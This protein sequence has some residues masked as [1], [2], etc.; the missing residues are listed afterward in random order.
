M[1]RTTKQLIAIAAV[2]STA[3]CS[4]LFNTSETSL[5]VSPAFQTIPMGFSANSNSFDVTGDAGLPFI[6][7]SMVEVG[8]HG[9]NSGPGS[10]GKDRDHHDG[11]GR[12][13]IR[14]LLM[15]GGIGPDF[16][17]S[18]AFGKGIGR[19][20]FGVFFLPETCTFS[21]AT[22]RVT[23][24]P[25]E[26]HGLTVN[27]SAAFK[28][29]AGNAQPKFDTVTTDLVN[30]QVDVNGTRTHRRG[31]DADKEGHDG[32]DVDHEVTST[33][34]HKSDRTVEG[35]ARGST[36]R[37]ING[38]AEAHENTRGTREGISF[39]AEREAFDTTTNLVIPI[40]EG[41]ATIP[42]TGTVIRRMTVS[43]AK[44]GREPR[45]KFRRE[46]ITFDGTNV[47]KIK[48]TQDDVTKN[49]TLTLPEK[50]FACAD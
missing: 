20:P 28:D 3:A 22:G 9:D 40:R 24:P 26:R 2:L 11:F 13:G 41:H 32:G 47:I 18:I 14:G 19:G 43:I 35:L 5:E 42:S 16:I 29:E 12:G 37:I 17:G 44:E 10:E 30:V 31:D 38:T 46:E 50:K 23:C 48:I 45:T 4:D 33:L 21:E 8:F 36:E 25:K 6:P 27:L 34:S 39:T 15:G 7:Q 49:C 1:S